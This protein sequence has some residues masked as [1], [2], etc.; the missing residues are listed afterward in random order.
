[1][2]EVCQVPNYKINYENTKK[3]VQPIEKIIS[4]MKSDLQLHERL[5]K[6]DNL[7]LAI[8]V[9]KLKKT[10]STKTLDDIMRDV[11]EFLTDPKGQTLFILHLNI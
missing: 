7:K 1:M 8:D 11:S 5:L 9:D 4:L 2:F 10:N 3:S 6:N